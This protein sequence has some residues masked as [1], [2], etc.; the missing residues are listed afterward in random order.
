CRTLLNECQPRPH[1]T[2]TDI[3]IVRPAIAVVVN[4][5]AL[6][7]LVQKPL[8][9]AVQTNYVFGLDAALRIR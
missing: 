1:R 2:G 3:M 8:S 5:G 9:D 4:I 7:L 6:P